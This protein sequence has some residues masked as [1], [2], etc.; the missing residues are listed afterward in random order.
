ML[1]EILEELVES[2][3]H[4]TFEN[5]LGCRGNFAFHFGMG[6]ITQVCGAIGLLCQVYHAGGFDRTNRTLRFSN[7]NDTRW[8]NN[9]ICWPPAISTSS[10]LSQPG[11]LSWRI[12]G[13]NSAENTSGRG[14]L[15]F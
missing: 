14:A 10:A 6:F 2:H 4:R 9:F 8:G 13:F 3:F 7:Q 5:D 12:S 11:I 15:I 1:L